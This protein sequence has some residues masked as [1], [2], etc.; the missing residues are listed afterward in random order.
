MNNQ[1]IDN[2]IAAQFGFGGTVSMLEFL[3]HNDVFASRIDSYLND[4]FRNSQGSWYQKMVVSS[5]QK[6]AERKLSEFAA[7]R[8]L[9]NFAGSIHK[10]AVGMLA[11]A[12]LDEVRVDDEELSDDERERPAPPHVELVQIRK[13]MPFSASRSYD[14]GVMILATNPSVPGCGCSQPAGSEVFG[15][16]GEIALR[17]VA[18]LLDRSLAR[19]SLALILPCP[20]YRYSRTVEESRRGFSV[21]TIN[22]VGSSLGEVIDFS[23]QFDP[24]EFALGRVNIEKSMSISSSSSGISAALQFPGAEQYLGEHIVNLGGYLQA[25]AAKLAGMHEH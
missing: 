25:S 8:H 12:R 2:P 15:R 9:H 14:D 22:T 7:R 23:L 3:L 19:P 1:T 21:I 17:Q 24:I 18:L 13:E 20:T 6:E 5:G 16:G 11:L 4:T 10:V